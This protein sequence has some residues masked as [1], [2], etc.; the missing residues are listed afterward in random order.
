MQI[1]QKIETKDEFR[2]KNYIP[3][4]IVVNMIVNHQKLNNDDHH[5]TSIPNRTI[6][7]QS[8][9]VLRASGHKNGQISSRIDENYSP[10]NEPLSTLLVLRH[11][12]WVYMVI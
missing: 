9:V 8:R 7:H 12:Q 1:F 6:S 10:Q 2:V 3:G 5:S 4:S 11:P